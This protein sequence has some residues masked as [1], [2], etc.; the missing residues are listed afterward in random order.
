MEYY[1]TSYLENS[2]IFETSHRDLVITAPFILGVID[3]QMQLAAEGASLIVKR[4]SL[5]NIAGVKDVPKVID[6]D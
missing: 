2:L 4:F 1:Y 3:S 6:E 5:E